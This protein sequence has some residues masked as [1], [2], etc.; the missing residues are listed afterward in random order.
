MIMTDLDQL[1]DDIADRGRPVRPYSTSGGRTLMALVVAA[2]LAVIYLVYGF[3]SDVMALEASPILF[4]TAG[5]MLMLG[6]AAGMSAVRMARPQV[7]AAPSSAPWLMAAL[8]LVPLMVLIRMMTGVSSHDGLAVGPGLYCLTL[9]FT[10]GIGTSGFLIGW[11]R[12]GAPV[13]PERASWMVGMAGGAAGSLAVTLEC[14]ADALAHLGIW[15]V[16][17]VPL[18]AL[19]SRLILPRLLRW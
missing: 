8:M 16:A 5:L 6:A 3:R 11:L 7:G 4:I 18:S 10:A 1:I 13:S 19:I 17:V 9:G 2:T 15:H 14:S 12:R